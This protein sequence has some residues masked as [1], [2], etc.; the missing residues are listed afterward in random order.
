[1]KFKATNSPIKSIVK[2][3]YK[4]A[5]LRRTDDETE[6]KGRLPLL[7]SIQPSINYRFEHE[8]RVYDFYDLRNMLQLSSPIGE[9]RELDNFR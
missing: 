9:T 4:N 1:M 8:K 6:K 3:Q 2:E 5:R 7:S